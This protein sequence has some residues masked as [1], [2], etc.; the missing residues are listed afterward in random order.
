[1]YWVC[2]CKDKKTMLFQIKRWATTLS[3]YFFFFFLVKRF[4]QFHIVFQ[5][6]ANRIGFVVS[7]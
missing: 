1:M 7:F 4:D 6:I 5:F 2:G 3:F